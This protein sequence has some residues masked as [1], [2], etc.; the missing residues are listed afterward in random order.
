MYASKSPLLMASISSSVTL[1]ISCFRA[2]AHKGKKKK[3]LK[4]AQKT[5]HYALADE[6]TRLW[7]T[8][9]LNHKRETVMFDSPVNGSYE[10]V[11]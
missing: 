3:M 8:F 10:S 4:T 2:I 5:S 6:Q 9:I 7:N 1:I 11:L